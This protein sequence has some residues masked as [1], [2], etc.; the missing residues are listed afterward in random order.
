MMRAQRTRARSCF[1]EQRP[2]GAAGAAALETADADTPRE[3]RR[4]E[5]AAAFTMRAMVLIVISVVSFFIP[6]RRYETNAAG[7]SRP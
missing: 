3:G 6:T 5:P 4:L 7:G 2:A 1:R